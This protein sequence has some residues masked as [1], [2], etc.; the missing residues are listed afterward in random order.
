MIL[1]AIEHA[2]N[3]HCIRINREGDRGAALEAEGAKP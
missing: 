1:T 2:K 3:H